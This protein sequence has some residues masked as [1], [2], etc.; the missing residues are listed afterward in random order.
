[1]RT[2]IIQNC[3][4]ELWLHA[5]SQ[6]PLFFLLISEN[7]SQIISYFSSSKKNHYY[8]Y[9]KLLKTLLKASTST[10]H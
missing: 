9:M 10:S 6:I 8:I 4:V 7:C 5:K 3:I 2:Q 1:M